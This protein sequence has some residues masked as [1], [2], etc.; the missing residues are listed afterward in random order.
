MLVWRAQNLRAEQPGL[1]RGAVHPGGRDVAGHGGGHLGADP[2]R[3]PGRNGVRAAGAAGGA[4]DLRKFRVFDLHAVR[5]S[6]LRHAGAGA[7]ASATAGAAGFAPGPPIMRLRLVSTTTV[8]D[9]PWE[10]FW[11]TRL[12]PPPRKPSVRPPGRSLPLPLSFVSLIAYQ[13]SACAA[14]CNSKNSYRFAQARNFRARPPGL[15]AACIYISCKIEK[16]PRS[17]KEVAVIYDLKVSEMT[18]GCKKFLEIMNLT[19]TRKNYVMSSSTPLNFIKRFCSKLDIVDDLFSLCQ[20]VAFMT[21]K[22]DIVDENTPPS[23]AAGCIFLVS[24]LCNLNIAKKMISTACKISEVTISKCYKK[25][26]AFRYNLIPK[27]AI[28]KYDIKMD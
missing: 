3:G 2:G 4:G 13:L 1:H 10:K 25:L 8:F 16:V 9:R 27:T 6:H 28:D 17:A 24:T 5:R 7:G 23:I 11:R 26:Y 18:K 21:T 15:M 20:I 19:K 14:P 22:L 12:W